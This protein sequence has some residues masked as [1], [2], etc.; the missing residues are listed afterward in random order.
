[1]E[2][3]LGRGK[4]RV[5][6]VAKAKTRKRKGRKGAKAEAK[7]EGSAHHKI[8]KAAGGGRVQGEKE[9]EACC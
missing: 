6:G 2:Q 9:E 4:A 3:I 1:M 7:S 8:K 5:G